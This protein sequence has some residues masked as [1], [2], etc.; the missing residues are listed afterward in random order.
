VRV[1]IVAPQ[2]PWPPH[3]GTTIRN[4]NI[5]R[6]V[7]GRHT[8]TL[9]AFGDPAAAVG[10]LHDLGIEVLAVPPPPPRSLPTRFID[11]FTTATPDLARRLSSPAM[12]AAIAPFDSRPF[13]V[14]QIEG[15]EMAAHGLAVHAALCGSRTGAGRPRLIY[16]GHNAEWV[17]QARARTADLRRPRGWPGAAYSVLQT[18]KLRRFERRLLA[19]ADAVVAVS[20]ADADALHA[21]APATRIAIVPNGVD[22]AFYT[23]ADP[24]AVDPDLCVFTGKMD[25]RPN[26][27]AMA[28]FCGEVWPLIRARR[29][30]AR[31]AIVGRDPAARVQALAD[32]ARGIAV[33][34]AVA[35]TRPWI[36]RA[37]VVVVPLRVG[38]GTRL[39]VLE[40]MAMAKAIAATSLG[41][42]GLDLAAGE[43]V[44]VADTP[45]AFA[46][47]VVQLMEDADLRR[48]LGAQARD[49]AVADYRWE[50]LVGAI[51]ALYAG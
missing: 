19:A 21:L 12:D 28:W 48:R 14:V 4:F 32:E 38:G 30:A 15:L 17:L 31:L 24:D 20:A 8:V 37:G 13:D 25:F 42:E 29:P 33:T 36:G 16:D 44:L 7:A 27:D 49:R 51:E 22:T 11:L 45:P 5:A 39:K 43:E 40:A 3:Q 34:G 35:D 26:I 10:P 50:V 41:V 46:A 1:L 47:A 2:V 23:P 6:H 18:W 9:L